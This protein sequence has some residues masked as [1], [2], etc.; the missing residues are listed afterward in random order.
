MVSPSDTDCMKTLAW[1]SEKGGT[2]KTTG[3]ICL[4]VALAKRG[5]RILLVDMDPQGNCS[6]TALSDELRG[7]P[8][9]FDVLCD[10]ALAS[11][12]I[13]ESRFDGV[14]IIPADGSLAEANLTLTGEMGREHRLRLA[15]EEVENDFDVA[16]IDTSPQRTLLTT[17]VMAFADDLIVPIDPGTYG[18]AGLKTLM[19]VVYQ[20]KKFLGNAQLAVL[21]IAL[22]RAQRNNM[23][24]QIERRLRV[25]YGELVFQQTI[26]NGVKVEEATSRNRCVLEYAPRDSVA[27]AYQALSEEIITRAQ[28]EDDQAAG[29]DGVNRVA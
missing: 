15:L 18:V 23:T 21:G 13:R 17:N 28:L 3:A 20:A 24:R 11:D 25:E 1:T 8:S 9:L 16:V 26:P 4:S 6:L 14:S 22:C 19:S 29:A 27:K 10:G 12:A 2:G 5:L 7:A